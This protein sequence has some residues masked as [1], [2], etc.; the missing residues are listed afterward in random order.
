MN[1][2]RNQSTGLAPAP[3]LSP[4]EGPKET[5]AATETN[6]IREPLSEA[7]EILNFNDFDDFDEF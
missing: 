6:K 1:V 4:Q 5:N 7:R 3:I 2:R